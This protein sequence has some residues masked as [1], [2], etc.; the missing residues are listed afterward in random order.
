LLLHSAGHDRALDPEAAITEVGALGNSLVGG[1][2]VERGVPKPSHDE[3]PEGGDNDHTG[4]P[5]APR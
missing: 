3:K 5:Q 4:D 2:E 1:A